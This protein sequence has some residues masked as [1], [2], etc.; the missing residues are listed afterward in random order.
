MKKLAVVLA[1]GALTCAMLGGCKNSD[2]FGGKKQ[3]SNEYITI[4]QYKK[5]EVPKV[6]Q[7]KITDEDVEN[8]IESQ[9]Q[10]EAT[11]KDVTDRAAQMDDTV[12][13]DFSGSV[14]G[15]QFDGGTAAG[16]DLVLGSNRFIGASGDY[17]G[18]EEQLVGHKTG[19]E[20]DIT[21]QFPQ[22]YNNADLAGKVAVFH[23]KINSIYV[24]EKPELNDEWVAKKSDK[25]KTVKEYKKELKKDMEKS[26]DER[27]QAQLQSSVGEALMEK[28]EVKKLPEDQVNAK[29]TEITDQWKKYAEEMQMD[30]V[31]FLQQYGGYDE[32][33]FNEQVQMVA[34]NTVKQEL[35]VRLIADEKK[36]TVSDEEYEKK[37]EE[38]VEM[39]N[40]PDVDALK[41]QY[42]E[43]NLRFSVL[44][45]KVSEYLVKSCVQVES[46]AT[47]TSTDG[48]NAGGTGTAGK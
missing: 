32:A 37:L 45:D 10:Q 1:V 13:I 21:V 20:F 3:L 35:A 43:E 47:G 36:I 33:T 25:S 27:V 19:E 30:F 26:N 15:V 23:I 5:L 39:S 18:F 17:K 42:S 31:E 16:F 11:K 12:N 40:L 24:M 34:E 9:L 48:A 29:K 7:T 6:E 14:D 46:S 4:T 41:E 2:L 22:E 28:V 8:A 44:A 38:Y